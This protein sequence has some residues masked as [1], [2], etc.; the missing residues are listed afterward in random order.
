M[1]WCVLGGGSSYSHEGAGA[2]TEY[3]VRLADL[4]FP[5]G[6]GACR[7]GCAGGD[8]AFDVVVEALDDVAGAG[9]FE[10]LS[11]DAEDGCFELFLGHM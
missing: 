5:P 3:P 2:P 11:L 8:G 10:V 4:G 6:G 7:T 1:S 9:L